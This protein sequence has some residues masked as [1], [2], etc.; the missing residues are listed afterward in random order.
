MDIREKE[1]KIIIISGKARSGK[2]TIA[3]M[4]KEIFDLKNIKSIKLAYA[5]YIKDYTKNIIDWNG[6]DE[7]KPRD[8]LQ[9]LGTD[10][11]RKNLGQDFFINRMIDDVKIYSYFYDVII[12]SDARL[13]R[14]ILLTKNNFEDVVSINIVRPNFVSEL[15]SNQ[16]KHI[17][18]TGLDNYDSYDYKIINDG[19]LE[20]L[21]VK[22]SEFVSELDFGEEK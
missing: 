19:T 12:I 20:D 18:E 15:N 17:T 2:D 16:N 13:E 4:M 5:D 9:F 21:N 11:I 6:K 14:E 10:L 7:T 3:D 1:A 22:V 8:F